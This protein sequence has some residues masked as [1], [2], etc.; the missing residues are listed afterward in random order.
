MVAI[1]TKP[2]RL[3]IGQKSQNA[4]PADVQHIL[5]IHLQG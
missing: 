1:M 2:E 5:D 4:K 3:E